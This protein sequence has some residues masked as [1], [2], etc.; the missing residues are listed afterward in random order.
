MMF[1]ATATHA[2]PSAV[3]DAGVPVVDDAAVPPVDAA[4]PPVEAPG[5]VDD[6]FEPNNSTPE[7][8]PLTPGVR[9]DATACSA[10]VDLYRFAAPVPAG[11][12]FLVTVSFTHALGDIDA[13]LI[14][15][16]SGAVVAVSESVFD[17][18]RLLVASDGGDYGVLVYL[19][20]GVGNTYSLDV[21]PIATHAESDCCTASGVPGCTVASVNDCVC[22]TDSQCCVEAFDDV[23]VT[24]AIAECGAACPRPPPVSDCCSAS[25][26]PGCSV[27][28]VQACVCAIDPFCCGVTFDPNCVNLAGAICGASCPVREP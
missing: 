6:A 13:R 22:L 12:L 27:P 4:V 23:C 16:T 26:T 24:Q 7:A 28:A 15:F 25:E 9:V 17:N 11:S 14:S 10:N 2:A 18:E 8:T 21:A 20:G 5:C 1:G 3:A 19:F